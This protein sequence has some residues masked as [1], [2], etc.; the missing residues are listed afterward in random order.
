MNNVYK[1]IRLIVEIL[2]GWK[3]EVPIAEAKKRANARFILWHSL[4]LQ[5]FLD[6]FTENNTSRINIMKMNW[7]TL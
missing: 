4:N 3:G 7:I 1:K 2:T 6:G 5:P